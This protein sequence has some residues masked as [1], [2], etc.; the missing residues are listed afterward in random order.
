MARL[1]LNAQREPETPSPAWL[2]Y[3]QLADRQLRAAQRDLKAHRATQPTQVALPTP[4]AATPPAPLSGICYP[5][6]LPIPQNPT[7]ARL[8]APLPAT[9][10]ALVAEIQR[11]T[12]LLTT[13][14]GSVEP[15]SNV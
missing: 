15:R 14:R 5:Q 1:H 8:D 10:E 6:S 2:R 4:P 13:R 3:E 11:L 7:L 12:T 9:P